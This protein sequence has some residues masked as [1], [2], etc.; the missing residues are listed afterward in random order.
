LSKVLKGEKTWPEVPL[1]K[2]QWSFLSQTLAELN[3]D[4][5]GP[6]GVLGKG[7][8]DA[9]DKRSRGVQLRVAALHLHRRRHHRGPEEHH[10]RPG[11]PAAPALGAG[12]VHHMNP[13]GAHVLVTGASSGI[14]AATARRLA[15]LGA[16]VGL[17][18][19]RGDRLASVL[20]ECQAHTPASRMWVADL[21]DLEGAERL[22]EEAWETLGGIDVL[23]NN[24]AIPKVRA[25]TALTPDVVEQTMR[26]NFFS[27]VRMTLKILPR[28]LARG[29][30]SH[31]QR[32][33]RGRAAGR[34]P[35]GGLQ[36]QQ[37]RLVRLELRPWP[38]TCTARP[39]RCG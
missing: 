11:H 9:V 35:R 5:L 3:V 7:G 8:P 20:G 2:L 23:I 19:R 4:M 34:R 14:G 21:G 37:V 29:R 18:G 33:Q 16:T 25:V 27:P 30:G 38:W 36:R 28:M 17:V 39:W 10:R 1:A 31:R 12:D 15:G 6:L 13:S 22:A 32:G 26:V 24:A